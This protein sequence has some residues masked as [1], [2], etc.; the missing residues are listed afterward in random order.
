MT[1]HVIWKQT[2]FISNSLND[3]PIKSLDVVFKGPYPLC[4]ISMSLPVHTVNT[5]NG[6][7]IGAGVHI[8]IPCVA[9]FRIEV[10]QNGKSVGGGI[11]PIHLIILMVNK[12]TVFMTDTPIGIPH[13]IIRLLNNTAVMTLYGR[14][15]IN[16]KQCIFRL[17]APW[18]KHVEIPL[19][20]KRSKTIGLSIK[21]TETSKRQDEKDE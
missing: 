14:I 15:T 19:R 18:V 17:T 12:I 20:T 3:L 6:H 4:S 21:G 9:N 5:H 7:Q 1:G 13:A 10:V 16:V 11:E 2:F 8:A